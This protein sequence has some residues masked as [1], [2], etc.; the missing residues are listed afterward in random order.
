MALCIY[1]YV[2]N[3]EV[4]SQCIHKN[5]FLGRKT[6]IGRG[7]VVIGFPGRAGGPSSWFGKPHVYIHVYFTNFLAT[8]C[9]WGTCYLLFLNG[10]GLW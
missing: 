8:V 10:I 5:Q 1:G 2:Q 6:N 3:F 7:A 9:V 4:N